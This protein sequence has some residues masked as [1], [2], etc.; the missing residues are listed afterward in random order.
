M[1]NQLGISKCI[2]DYSHDS[3]D[4]IVNNA[5]VAVNGPLGN[6]TPQ[7]F[8]YQ[9]DVNVVGP[10]MMVQAALPYLPN[11]RSGRIVN[12]SS[13]SATMGFAGQ[14]IYGGTKAALDS[15]TRTWSRELAERATVNAVNPGPVATDM[16]RGAAAAGGFEAAL[17][18]LVQMTPLARMREGVD[19]EEMMKTG[20]RLAGRP[21]YDHEIAGVVGMLCSEESGW[22]TGSVVCANGGAKFSS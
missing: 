2:Y 14:T 17:R 15:M 13:I 5:G 12:V 7:D 6:L 9:Y 8:K 10:A 20:E 21:A 3:S 11:D 16:W 18:P 1:V 22:C 4:I 19:S